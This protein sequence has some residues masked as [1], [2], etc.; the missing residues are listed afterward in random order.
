VPQIR[1]S[2]K[3]PW[4]I[5]LRGLDIRNADS[6]IEK[7]LSNS[8]NPP[9]LHPYCQKDPLESW[10]HPPKYDE[11]L[12]YSNI[13]TVLKAS[14]L[15]QKATCQSN[16]C[17][18]PFDETL[19]Q[20]LP[21]FE[22]LA[23]NFGLG[24][25]PKFKERAV[26]VERKP[27]V[28]VRVKNCCKCDETPMIAR[29]KRCTCDHLYCTICK[30]IPKAPVALPLNC[31][32]YTLVRLSKGE[33]Y[34]GVDIRGVI[35]GVARRF[36]AISTVELPDESWEMAILE[37]YFSTLEDQLGKIL[38]GS[39]LDLIDD[40][41]KPS[42]EEVKIFGYAL[43]KARKTDAFL[44]LADEM[45]ETGLPGAVQ[46]YSWLKFSQGHKSQIYYLVL[47]FC[48]Y[49]GSTHISMCANYVSTT[50]LL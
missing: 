33:H 18:P 42:K 50:G 14:A 45:I 16:A 22:A 43:A 12:S 39:K 15:A 32:A 21:R 48:M 47:F 34:E 26:K 31:K 36:Q 3:S 41:T 38:P 23:S 13:P 20:R 19:P 4:G 2:T 35:D 24:I 6:D 29:S 46:I 37:S 40:P 7:G 1:K 25:L 28:R 27:R 44:R 49:F 9:H 5:G 11:A 8:Q 17:L 30:Y 10:Y